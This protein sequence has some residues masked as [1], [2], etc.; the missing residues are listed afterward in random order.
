MKQLQL[1]KFNGKSWEYG[2]VISGAG[3]V[4]SE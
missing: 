4:V 2:E 3:E 1:I